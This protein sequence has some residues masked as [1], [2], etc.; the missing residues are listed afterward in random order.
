MNMVCKHVLSIYGIFNFPI[1]SYGKGYS[2]LKNI[3]IIKGGLLQLCHIEVSNTR[4]EI[5]KKLIFQL[6]YQFSNM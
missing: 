6:E 3:R 2:C 1:V 4:G 5:E